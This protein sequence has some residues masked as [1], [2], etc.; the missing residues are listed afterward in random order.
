MDFPILSTLLFF[1]SITPS[2]T[3]SIDRPFSVFN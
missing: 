2:S 1:E 3:T